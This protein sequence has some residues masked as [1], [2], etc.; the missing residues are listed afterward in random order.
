MGGGV[1]TPELAAAVCAAGALGMVSSIGPAP[2]GE[3]LNALGGL[4]DAP[5]GVGFFGFDI[6]NR[7]AELELAASQARVVDVFWGQP[8]AAVVARIHAGGALALWQVGSADEAVAAAD[9]GCDAVVAQG[10]EAGGH[11]RGTIGMLPLLVEVVEAVDVP[12]L[13]AGGIGTGRAMAAALA[14]GASGVRVGTRFLASPES[15]AHPEYVER[16]IAARAEDTVYTTAFSGG[17]PDAPPRVLRSCLEAA[18]A[19][20]DDIVG[21]RSSLDGKRVPIKR[22]DAAS[23][24]RDAT[25]AIGAMSLWAGESVGGVTKV[26][27]AA[28]VVQEMAAEAEALLRRW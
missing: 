2:L 27:P 17:W 26:Q 19:F 20:P 11:V 16:L 18:E 22:F 28:E 25:G 14:A 1:G 21:E 7:V 9:A 13:A 12:V 23:V 5:Y 3:Q 15:D 10:V 4:T 6:P 8:D 24:P